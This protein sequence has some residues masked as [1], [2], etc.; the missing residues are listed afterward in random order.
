VESLFQNKIPHAR[1]VEKNHLNLESIVVV[2]A[3]PFVMSMDGIVLN[4]GHLTLPV[5]Y[6]VHG[7]LYALESLQ[8]YF[9]FSLL[10]FS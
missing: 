10:G 6:V 8:A 7:E 4:V 5:Q 2:V 9:S 3:K 1:L